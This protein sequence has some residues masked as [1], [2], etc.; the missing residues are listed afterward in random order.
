MLSSHNAPVRIKSN[1]VCVLSFTCLRPTDCGFSVS[2]TVTGVTL[3]WTNIQFKR[4]KYFNCFCTDNPGICCCNVIHWSEQWW[5]HCPFP[6][7]IHVLW[8]LLSVRKPLSAK[9]T[10]CSVSQV[11]DL[12]SVSHSMFI[13]FSGRTTTLGSSA[14]SDLCPFACGV[15]Y[16]PSSVQ[17]EYSLHP[18]QG[19]QG[20]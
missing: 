6:H 8:V 7:N 20:S 9:F 16:S 12:A 4:R 2:V 14:F 13:F 10:F 11:L 5:H 18:L 1:T 19:Y 17:G 3:S 15:L